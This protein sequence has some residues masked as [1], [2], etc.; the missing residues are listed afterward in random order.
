MVSGNLCG[1]SH[2][3]ESLSRARGT[4]S[5]GLLAFLLG[6]ALMAPGALAH[7]VNPGNAGHGDCY[8]REEGVPGTPPP[9]AYWIISGNDSNNGCSGHDGDKDIMSAGGGSD[10]M[11]GLEGPD[12]I[13]GQGGGDDLAGGAGRDR[14]EDDFSGDSDRLC[15]GDGNEEVVDSEDNDGN[16]VIWMSHDGI[17]NSNEGI[18]KDPGD[19]INTGPCPFL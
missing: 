14:I 4:G 12:D 18:Q 10:E 5:T 3:R 13:K 11:R 6:A 19:N 2:R 16:D 9:P 17:D 7:E 15:D 1:K 8:S